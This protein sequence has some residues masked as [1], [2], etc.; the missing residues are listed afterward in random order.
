[1]RS[2]VNQWKEMEREL[3][4]TEE[5]M[6]FFLEINGNLANTTHCSWERW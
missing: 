2:S 6:D 3:K 5:L 1:M 4:L